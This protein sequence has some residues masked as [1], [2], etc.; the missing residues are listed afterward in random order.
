[1]ASK[2]RKPRKL[3]EGILIRGADGVLYFVS[4]RKLKAFRVPEE[5]GAKT[6]AKFDAWAVGDRK[7]ALQAV[8]G[9]KVNFEEVLVC[10]PIKGPRRRKSSS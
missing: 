3:I 6:H 7:G 2:S 1:M 10:H 8:C 9:C 5:A 4:N